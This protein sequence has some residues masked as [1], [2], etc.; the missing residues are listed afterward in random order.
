MN[1]L[2]SV[3]G[4]LSLSAFTWAACGGG[5]PSLSGTRES[6]QSGLMDQTFAGKNKCNP[7]NHDRPFIIEWDATDM[8][9]FESYAANDVVVVR[10]EGCDLKVL[11]QC[12]NDSVRGSL[13]A[14]KP[15]EWTSGSLEKMDI[16]NEGELVA[17]L[18]LGAATLGGRV[19]AGEKFHMEYY[20]AGTRT[21]TRDGVYRADLEK[22]PGCK[23]ATHFVYGY[24]LGAFALGSVQE[25]NAA[26]DVSIYG[27]GGGG[28]KKSSQAADKKGGDL[29]TCKSD[30]AKEIEGCK[31]P[32][33]LTLRSIKSG[34]S[35]E[36]SAMKAPD[37]SE[38]VTAAGMVNTKIEMSEEARARYDAATLK[39]NSKDGKGCLTELDAHDV[40][41]PKHKSSDPKS[42]IGYM[43]AQCL[44]LAGQ[45]AAGKT[46]MRKSLEVTHAA[47][48]TPEHMD[49]MVDGYA[50]MACQGGDMTARDKVLKG[51]KDLSDG[52]FLGK[53]S[54][55][56]CMSAYNTVRTHAPTVKP[57]DD[58][59]RQIIDYQRNLF[60]TAPQ[61]LAKVGDCKN[62]WKV[63]QEV[64][65]AESKAGVK[66]PKQLETT[67]KAVFES[68]VK[69]CKQ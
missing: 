55:E 42:G 58:D 47:S 8:S 53:K 24:N 37:T 30:S 34:E 62:S 48:T 67:M 11:D 14:Y 12:R 54:T 45:C 5:V 29:A 31:A 63:F 56:F 35:P 46:L 51:L 15:V 1:R 65:P 23:G 36:A 60:A 50:S 33:R 61:C 16:S 22:L 40:L 41:D 18:P 49:R 13:G 9:S 32:I 52:A 6:G 19:Q 57:K 21:A 25:L 7:E 27:F 59:D 64:Y 3:L 43:R 39:M 28:S 68:M 44:M 69:Q 4:L 17:K 38:S 10:Y 66:D 2:R 20:V 26:A